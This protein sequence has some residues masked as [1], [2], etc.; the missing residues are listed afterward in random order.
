MTTHAEPESNYSSINVYSTPDCNPQETTEL[1]Q[2]GQ[3][4]LKP[5]FLSAII[6]ALLFCGIIVTIIVTRNLNASLSPSSTASTTNTGQAYN[7]FI[8]EDTNYLDSNAITS[9]CDSAIDCNAHGRCSY[10]S[11]Y[12][13]CDIG[14]TT[15]AAPNGTECNYK[16]KYQMNA[17]LLSL[18]LGG[19]GAGRYYVGDYVLATV[20]LLLI[21]VG[22]YIACITMMS[23][24]GT[25]N[26]SLLVCGYCVLFCSACTLGVWVIVDIVLFACNDIPDGN[27]V[28][29]APW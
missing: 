22:C 19:F 24:Y 14:Y 23:G 10:D 7:T 15:Y 18:F 6:S 17:F 4:K 20:K 2:S 1:I 8:D 16:Q 29:L 5:I 9:D 25:D 12:C 3:S 11:T 28:A 13:V 26:S 27:G 21:F